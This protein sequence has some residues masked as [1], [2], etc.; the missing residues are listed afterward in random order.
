MLRRWYVTGMVFLGL[1]LFVGCQATRNALDPMPT[2]KG[3]RIESKLRDIPKPD[4]AKVKTVTV[5]R[6]Q[7][8]TGFP[9]GLQLTNGMLDMLMTA[10]VDTG[11]FRVVERE[12]LDEIMTEKDLQRAGE[13]TGGAGSTKMH[14][15]DLIFKGAVT[16]L[17]QTGGG[18]F[19]LHHGDVGVGLETWTANVGLDIRVID[20]ATSEVMGS[21]DV[22]KTTRR[23]GISGS[24][25][26]G[27]SGGVEISNALDLAIRETIDEA[28]YQLVTRYGAK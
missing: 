7:N 1:G 26:W 20:A 13:A 4:P 16:E 21:V 17:D 15:A 3:S 2:T 12:G 5:Y 18:D 11:H 6:F 27:V 9:H 25:R 10:L 19:R 14:G 23:T 24:H 8:K 22:R 28:V